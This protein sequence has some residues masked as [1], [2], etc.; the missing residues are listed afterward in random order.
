MI[1]LLLTG[2]ALLVVGA[3]AYTPALTQT[4]DETKSAASKSS[5][6]KRFG[7]KGAASKRA[8]LKL[9]KDGRPLSTK[10]LAARTALCRA[11]CRP[12]NYNRKTGIG[13]H[14]VYR[15]YATFDPT[16]MSVEGKRQ[17]ADCVRVC[18]A[19]L[20]AVYIQRAVFA[21]GVNSWFGKSKES[22]LDCHVKG[23]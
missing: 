16:L 12:G 3:L 22:C 14:G 9:D 18:L 19:P 20:P 7:P 13:I 4:A 15:S 23:H 5:A 1:K 6:P 11:D 8:R 10:S 21:T 17:F 2:A